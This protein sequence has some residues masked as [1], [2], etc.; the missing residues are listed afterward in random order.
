MDRRTSVPSD[1]WAVRLMGRR[2]IGLD[3]FCLK[4]SNKLKPGTPFLFSYSV[5]FAWVCILYRG[6]SGA[7][8][9]KRFTFLYT[10]RL[11]MCNITF[12]VP[13]LSNSL[14]KCSEK[15]NTIIFLVKS[16]KGFGWNNV[17]PASQTM[18]QHYISIGPMYRVIWCSWRWDVKVYNRPGDRLVLSHL[19][20]QWLQCWPNIEPEFG[21]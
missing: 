13:R 10:S 20:Q 5:Y 6:K 3:I 9:G 21:G 15:I 18:A 16:S 7:V 11:N 14:N 8:C 12:Q 19:N 4:H 17:G 2:T 1:Q